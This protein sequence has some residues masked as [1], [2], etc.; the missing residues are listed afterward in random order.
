MEVGDDPNLADQILVCFE[1][2][3]LAGLPSGLSVGAGSVEAVLEGRFVNLPY[4][5][6]VG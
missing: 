6:E 2:P 1:V 4:H 5:P 3:S